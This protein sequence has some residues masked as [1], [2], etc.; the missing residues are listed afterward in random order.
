MF[1]Y[2]GLALA[3]DSRVYE[4]AEDSFLLAD[5]L[6]NTKLMKSMDALEIGVG[7]GIISL[8]LAKKCKSVT[9]VDINQHAIN[10][11]KK[12]AEL[13]KV[14][15]VRFFESDLFEYVQGLF[16]VI[17]F[18][19]PYVPTDGE[20]EDPAWDGGKTGRIV[21]DRFLEKAPAFLKENG[22]ILT[23]ESSLSDYKK[24]LLFF[25]KKGMD[26]NVVEKQKLDFEE[27]VCIEA[28]FV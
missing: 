9:G 22:K 18:N 26:A 1:T 28:S 7:T 11:A 25:A 4:P 20:K 27:I 5:A 24:T 10:L 6:K 14:K 2:E 21:I 16:D 13:N 23:V 17:V 12:N 3:F 15:N 19:T 8:L